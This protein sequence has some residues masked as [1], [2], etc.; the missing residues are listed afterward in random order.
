MDD[1]GKR[2]N[3]ERLVDG[4]SNK[5]RGDKEELGGEFRRGRVEGEGEEKGK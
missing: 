5:G 2:G 3:E 1:E 4:V